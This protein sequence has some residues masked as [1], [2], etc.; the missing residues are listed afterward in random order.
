M[1]G[2]RHGAGRVD[3]MAAVAEQDTNGVK[4]GGD[5]FGHGRGF[6]G[7]ILG[8]IGRRGGLRIGRYVGF[9]VIYNNS[10]LAWKQGLF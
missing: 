4:D 10:M 1:W 3:E 8:W 6:A 2:R 7:L 9:H 5:V